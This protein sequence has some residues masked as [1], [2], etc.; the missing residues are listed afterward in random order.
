MVDSSCSIH[1]GGAARLCRRPLPECRCDIL[2]EIKS[3]LKS[4]GMFDNLKVAQNMMKNMSPK[5]IME[6]ME[7][8][9]NQKTMMEDM[10]RK[11]V[12]EELDKRGL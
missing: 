1:V 6:L 7:T 5:E 9:K 10:V 4:M 11:I 3:F 2:D 12:Q 8:A